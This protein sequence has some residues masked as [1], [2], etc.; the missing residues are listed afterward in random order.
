MF[1]LFYHFYK[2]LNHFLNDQ[3]NKLPCETTEP[4]LNTN[5]S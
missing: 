2:F 4:P 3:K 5:G 1:I